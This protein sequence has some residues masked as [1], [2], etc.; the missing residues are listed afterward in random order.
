MT[1]QDLLLAESHAFRGKT[2]LVWMQG[3]N[4]VALRAKSQAVGV[5]TSYL[6]RSKVAGSVGAV[7]GIC[8]VVSFQALLL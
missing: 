7:Q 3:K 6:N 1:L 8:T 4:R 5:L 2:I